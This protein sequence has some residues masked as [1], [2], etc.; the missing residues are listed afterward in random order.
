MRP[1]IVVHN[2]VAA[3]GAVRGFSVDMGVHYGLA[4]GFGAQAHLIGS[5]TALSG[6]EEFADD[7]AP[8]QES[9]CR[10]PETAS[11]GE[12]PWWVLVDSGGKLLGYLHGLRRFEFCRDVVVLIGEATPAPYLEYLR[13]RAYRHHVVGEEEVSLPRAMELL[14]AEYQVER[15]LVDSGPRLVAALL[16]QDLVDRLSLVVSPSL[17]G[18]EHPALFSRSGRR[19][20]MELLSHTEVG[21]GAVHLVYRLPTR[22]RGA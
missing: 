15:V 4:A 5:G 6:L 10:P 22:A 16:D 8:E 3:D 17:A 21:D 20:E 2:T 12:L 13:T 19:A 18:S 14:A 9:D 7:V 11:N 1:E